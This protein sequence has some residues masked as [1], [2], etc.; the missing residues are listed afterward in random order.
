MAGERQRAKQEPEKELLFQAGEDTDEV[1]TL[2]S[3]INDQNPDAEITVRRADKA[4]NNKMAFIGAYPVGEYTWSAL[5]TMLRDTYGSGFYRFFISEGGKLIKNIGLPIEAPPKGLE[6]AR[7]AGNNNDLISLFRDMSERQN[8]ELREMLKEMKRPGFDYKFWA[9]LLL[10]VLS[11]AG[12]ALL[13]ALKGDRRDP[14]AMM[15]QMMTLQT[16]MREFMGDAPPPPEEPEGIAGILKT[17]LPMLGQIAQ[18]AMAPKGAPQTMT[19][20]V[21]PHPAQN[22]AP[23]ESVQELPQQPAPVDPAALFNKMVLQIIKWASEDR[24]PAIYAVVFEDNL[25]P[26]FAAPVLQIMSAEDW[27]TKLSMLNADVIPHQEWITELR[28]EFLE[29]QKAEESN[30]ETAGE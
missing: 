4:G 24:D 5:L 3:E 8:A 6:T 7:V 19:A 26:E 9:P 1:G 14:I 29:L 11:T 17:A 16:Q 15:Q 22:P 18:T 21:Q 20:T 27:F 12:P 2:L 10:P 30:D 25:P 28:N 23:K 13:N